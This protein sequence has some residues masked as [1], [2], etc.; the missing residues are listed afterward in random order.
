MGGVVSDDILLARAYLSRVAEPACIPVWD[1]VRCLGPVAAAR[2]I[3]DGAGSP[4]VS[5]ATAARR[6]H[7]DPQADLDVAQRHGIRLVV[8]ES[9]EWPHFALAALE[10]TGRARARRFQAGERK[11]SDSGEPMPPL[12]LWVKGPG[13]LAALGV[14]SVGIVGSR[15]ATA[16]GEHVTADL[17][18]GLAGR[19]VVVVSGGAYGIDAAAH[20]G[21]LAAG[22]QTVVVSAGG[23]DRPY[24]TGNAAL[25]TRAAESGLVISESPPGAAPQ[26]HR[27]LTR[28]RLIAALSTGTVVVEAARRSGAANTAHHCLTLGRPVMAVPGPVT[29][30]MSAGCHDLLRRENDPALLVT[31]VDDV[32][33]VVGAMGDGIAADQRPPADPIAGDVR[34]ELDVLDPVARRVFEGLPV[35]RPARPDE[36]AQRCGVTPLEVIRSLPVLDLAGLLEASD[37]GYR[38]A[39]RLRPR[40]RRV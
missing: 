39:A 17:G 21:A 16:Y 31:C 28:N 25:F 23:L 36:I 27:F 9:D 6:E 34:A 7:A 19:G 12:A 30:P 32:V 20:R 29:S 4:E 10:R 37:A 11:V 33:A 5:A 38:I 3:R 8:P 18:Y 13:E 15:A 1:C 26:R 35:R 24:P 14:R 22:G 2:L 40:R